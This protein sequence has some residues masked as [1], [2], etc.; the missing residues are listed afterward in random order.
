MVNINLL[1]S[2]LA[3]SIS[4][5]IGLISMIPS[6]IGSS[7]MSYVYIMGLLGYESAN[8]VAGSLVAKFLFLFSTFIGG[9]LC[10]YLD[11]EKSN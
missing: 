11:K 2:V 9:Y 5:V 6:G 3:Q 8:L 4:V 10:V 1:D 7:T